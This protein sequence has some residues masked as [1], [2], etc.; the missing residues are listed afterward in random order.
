[1]QLIGMLDSPYVRRVAIS[2][3]LLDLTFTHR[4]LSVFRDAGAFRSLNPVLKAPTLICRDGQRLMDSNLILAYGEHLA[5]GR[6]LLP[7]PSASRLTALSRT[8]LALALCEKAIQLLYERDL[9]PEEKRHEPWQQRVEGQLRAACGALDKAWLGP[10]PPLGED[11]IGQD[12]I[13]TAVAWTFLHFALPGLI[14]RRN[15]P[16]LEALTVEAEALSVFR[17]YSLA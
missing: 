17:D 16:T 9:R 3:R 13:D 2:Y 4:A 8:G 7:L 12:A 1:M 5:L 15:Y 10:R 14:E 11:S 6:S